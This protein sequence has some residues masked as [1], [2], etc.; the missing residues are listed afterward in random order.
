MGN[1]DMWMRLV[2]I[3]AALLAVFVL[4]FLG[5]PF[6]ASELH[7]RVMDQPVPDVSLRDADG[8]PTSLSRWEGHPVYL[9]FGYLGCEDVCHSQAFTLQGI[10]QRSGREDLRFVYIAMDPA[11]DEPA[12]VERYFD[13][14]GARFTSLHAPD[15]ATIQMVANRFNA[16][17]SPDGRGEYELDHPGFIYLID[18]RQRIRTLYS[19]AT[20]S[21][22][23]MLEDLARIAP[24]G[25]NS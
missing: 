15:Q 14:R 9:M 6:S 21:I 24:R 1:S 10:A 5:N 2:W 16:P 25:E 3:A 12:R 17:Y 8:R 22:P 13:D 7:G 20:P 11:R 19:G 18:A 23:L 4:P